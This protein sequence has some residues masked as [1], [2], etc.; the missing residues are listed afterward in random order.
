MKPLISVIMPLFNAAETVQFA[1]AS[2]QA[3]TCG[4]WECII[5]D[6]GSSD[7][8]EQAVSAVRDSRIKY[9]RL[10]RNHGRGYARQL[11]LNVASGNYITFLDADD[12]LYPDKFE[13]QAELL[14]SDA[15]LE[16]VSTGMA[17]S[18]A[19]DELLGVRG[20]RRHAPVI[21]GE[22][23]QIG[24]PPLAFAPSMIASKLAKKSGF[25]PSFPIA[26]DVDFLLRALYGKGYAILPEPLYVYREHGSATLDK[27]VSA[28]DY[29]CLIF[30]KQVD[31]HLVES[32]FEITKAR[33]KQMIYRLA[34]N[35]GLWNYVI[36]RRSQTPTAAD[37]GRYQQAWQT[38]FE[39]TT[40]SILQA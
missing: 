13:A 9:R 5:V 16:V 35:L 28:L 19:K 32:A 27:V 29:C 34:A 31:E 15:E 12:W 23:R 24:M 38:V 37:W 40:A 22:F 11:G 6:D 17:I 8:S 36:H 2:L 39:A 18:N 33:G 21:R 7:G 20:A 26:E 10:G 4:D 25:D 1:L 14:E 3:Q 30:D